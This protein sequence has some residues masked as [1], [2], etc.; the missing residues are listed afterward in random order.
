MWFKAASKRELRN[1]MWRRRLIASLAR[2]QQD[3]D[4]RGRSAADVMKSPAIPVALQI[5]KRLFDLH[6]R[7]V[8]VDDSGSTVVQRRHQYQGL[9]GRSASLLISRTLPWRSMNTERRRSL[10]FL[11]CV[12]RVAKLRYRPLDRRASQQSINS[13]D[14]VLIDGSTRQAS[15]Q[16]LKLTAVE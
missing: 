3:V 2:K 9:S 15:P 10:S 8:D 1:L 14:P 5:A 16:K 6:A 13:L 7:A 11:P 4:A 12:R